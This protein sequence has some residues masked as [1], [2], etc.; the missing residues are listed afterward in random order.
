M[1]IEQ[2]KFEFKINKKNNRKI[3]KIIKFQKINEKNNNSRINLNQ[4]Q[5]SKNKFG[6][7]LKINS[8]IIDYY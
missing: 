4:F 5:K 6:I 2:Y 3:I 8:R 7:N 1:N